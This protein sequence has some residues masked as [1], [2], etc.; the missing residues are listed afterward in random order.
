MRDKGI[1]YLINGDRNW[2]QVLPRITFDQDYAA[3]NTHNGWLALTVC[4]TTFSWVT[5]REIGKRVDHVQDL[6]WMAG[7]FDFQHILS[8]LAYD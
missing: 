2:H 5:L 7:K 3:M 4:F 8:Q 1:S 6:G